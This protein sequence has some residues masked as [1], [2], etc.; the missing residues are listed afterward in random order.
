MMGFRPLLKKLKL[1]APHSSRTTAIPV[2]LNAALYFR[3][4]YNIW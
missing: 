2:N 1:E 3:L 4:F